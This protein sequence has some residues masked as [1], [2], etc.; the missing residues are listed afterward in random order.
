MDVTLKKMDQ[1]DIKYI[2]DRIYNDKFVTTNQKTYHV[3]NDVEWDNSNKIFHSMD[4]KLAIRGESFYDRISL[5]ES[6]D[7]TLDKIMIA[8]KHHE[9]KYQ[10]GRN[11]RSDDVKFIIKTM[12]DS[13]IKNRISEANYVSDFLISRQDGINY[14]EWFRY[15]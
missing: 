11:D 9:I 6:S 13:D 2:A 8:L 5:Y 1:F 10:L 12:Y 7:W 3:A 15:S 4:K 14:V